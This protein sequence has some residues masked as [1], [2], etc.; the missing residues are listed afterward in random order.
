M[1]SDISEALRRLVAER[2]D[3]L[4]EYCLVHEADVYHGCEVDHV[5]SVKHGGTTVP[6]NLAY[7]CFHCNRH[8][9]ADLGSLS[10][11]TGKLVRFFNPRSDYWPQ[12]FSLIEARIDPVTEIGEVTSRVLEFNHPERLAFR[13]LLMEVGRYLT[14]EALARLKG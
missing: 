1:R 6:D 7:A 13:R 3:H 12:H 14:V 2:A 4:C 8:K 5:V 9:G 10:L 11:R